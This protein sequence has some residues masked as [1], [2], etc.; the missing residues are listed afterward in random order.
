MTSLLVVG[1]GL[2]GLSAVRAARELGFTGSIRVLG[3]EPGRPYDRP[4]LSKDYLAGRADAA[5]LELDAPQED[6]GAEWLVGSAASLEPGRGVVTTDGRRLEAD[7]IVLASGARARTLPQLPHAYENVLVLRTRDD[8]DR[9]RRELAPGRHLVVVGAGL[10]GCEVA[11][12]ASELGCRVTLLTPEVVP[13]ERIYGARLAPRLLDL[14]RGRG[15]SVRTEVSVDRVE[16]AG[17]RATA[18][19]LEDGEVIAADVV[20]VAVGAEPETEWLHGAGVDLGD[21]VRCDAS[22]RVLAGGR[23][24]PGV[25]AVGDCAAWWDPH[26][27]RHHR[28]QHWTDALERPGRAVAALLGVA[29]PPRKPYLPYFWSD[30][31]G[32]R[33][34]MAGYASLA[35]SVEVEPDAATTRTARTPV[36]ADGFLAVYRR[37]GEPV[38][39]L[40]LDRPR[41]FVRWRKSLVASLGQ[42]PEIPTVAAS[43]S[44]PSVAAPAPAAPIPDEGA[45][46]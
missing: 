22:G 29:A 41:E 20:L 16:V 14:H 10:V 19:R 7:G 38:A 11:A 39:V 6:L 9:L 26:L 44:A 28:T 27:A 12:T 46:A 3:A 8:A 13:L 33:I 40:S 23:P 24:V 30:Q 35:D 32:H 45:A 17:N 42:L 2:A 31:H 15:V 4:P 18:L 21:G 43:G 37:A 34:Q 36:G 25:V 1:N 5:D